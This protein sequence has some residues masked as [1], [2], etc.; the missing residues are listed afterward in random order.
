MSDPCA[1]PLGEEALGVAISLMKEKGEGTTIYEH[2]DL[3]QT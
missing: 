3:H 1:D 2:S